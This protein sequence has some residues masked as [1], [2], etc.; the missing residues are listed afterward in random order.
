MLMKKGALK[1]IFF[2]II[3]AGLFSPGCSSLIKNPVVTAPIFE[4][5][6]SELE[7]DEFPEMIKQ[8][9]DIAQNNESMSLRARAHFY[10]ALIDIHYKNPMPDYSSALKHL[11]EYIALD[12]ENERIDEIVIWM[13]VLRDLD[14]SIREYNDLKKKYELVKQENERAK[15]D[16]KDLNQE[17]NEL[18]RTIETQKKEISSLEEKI[19]KLDS[20]Y[21]EIEKKKKKIKK[22]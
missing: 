1:K 17:R 3:A 8:L 10:I 2:L 22:K 6:L 14:S 5:D 16:R 12:P 7:P 18:V 21:I 11:N 20:L 13:S 4:T 19:K 15:K 9:E